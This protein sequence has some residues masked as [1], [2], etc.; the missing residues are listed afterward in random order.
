MA[1]SLC[2]APS[3]TRKGKSEEAAADDGDAEDVY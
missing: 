1:R 2:L 3:L